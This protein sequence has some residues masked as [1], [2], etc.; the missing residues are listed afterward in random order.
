M[1]SAAGLALVAGLAAGGFLGDVFGLVA[2][3]SIAASL[4]AVGGLL[5]FIFMP[6]TAVTEESAQPEAVALPE[7]E[8][9][10]PVE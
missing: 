3:L 2:M 8:P 4:R 9:A 6:R 10:V 5:V 7:S 1:G